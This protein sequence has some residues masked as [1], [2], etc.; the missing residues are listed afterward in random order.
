MMTKE[1]VLSIFKTHP[2]GN[3]E[4]SNFKT[5]FPEH[6][7]IFSTWVFPPDFKFTQKLFHYFNDDPELK[8]GL[9][10]VCG[11]R[12]KF[13]SFGIGYTHHCSVRCS[14]LDNN[15]QIKMKETSI[16]KWGYEY[17]S[18]SPKFRAQVIQ[19]CNEKYG[20]DN[21]SQVNEIIEKKKQ[22]KL[23]RYGD[24]GYH[25]IKKMKQTNLQRYG[26]ESTFSNE[27]IRNKAQET[28]RKI[29]GVDNPFQSEIIKDKIKQTNIQLY[30]CEHNMQSEKVRE[31]AYATK[32][33][34]HTFNTSCVEI[35]LTKWFKDN[36]IDILT[37]YK[38]DK[39]PYMCDFYLPK[40]DLFIEIQGCWTHG[41][42]P[43]DK[44]N[45]D[46]IK[47]LHKWISKNTKYYDNAIEVWTKRDVEK[48]QIA[49]RNNLNF[50]EIF[51]K[52][53]DVVIKEISKILKNKRETI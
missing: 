5:K 30:N 15:V 27:S 11:K 50:V 35:E 34:N 45:K 25:N 8:F 7:Q 14:T 32:R 43:F 6:Y 38:C 3:I 53:P 24:M 49:Q 31:K 46:D 12:C 18:Q 28:I 52:Y 13:V 44:N 23:E 40:Y 48:R 42:H 33:K 36:N 1:E 26:C 16:K 9:C 21:I 10:P 51:S 37:Q 29:Y 17:P 20:C 4:E 47:I 39:Y 19:T 22:T 2:N 41:G